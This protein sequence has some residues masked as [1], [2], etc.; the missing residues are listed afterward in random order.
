LLARAAPHGVTLTPL[1]NDQKADA[2]AINRLSSRNIAKHFKG[3]ATAMR[4]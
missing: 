2:R 1:I 4:M 3:N